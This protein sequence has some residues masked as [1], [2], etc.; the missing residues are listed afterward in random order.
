MPRPFKEQDLKAGSA[1]KRDASFAIVPLYVTL[2]SKPAA[3]A[4]EDNSF[5]FFKGIWRREHNF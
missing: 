2:R 3:C 4:S 1:E 5:F